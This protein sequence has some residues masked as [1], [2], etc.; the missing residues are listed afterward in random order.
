MGPLYVALFCGLAWVSGA[1][2][3]LGMM[4][5]ELPLPFLGKGTRPARRERPV[6]RQYRAWDRSYRT[7]RLMSL[8]GTSLLIVLLVSAFGALAYLL[9]SH[10]YQIR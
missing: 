1:L 9:V 7:Q 6:E 4:R 8:I 2:F 3:G 10:D 5:Y